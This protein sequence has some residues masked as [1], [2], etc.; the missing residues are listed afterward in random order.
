[1]ENNTIQCPYCLKKVRKG[2]TYALDV[3]QLYYTVLRRV[4]AYF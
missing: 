4:G 3:K 2:F 1:M